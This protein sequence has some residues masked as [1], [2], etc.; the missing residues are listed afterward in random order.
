M[1]TGH[2]NEIFYEQGTYLLMR[3]VAVICVLLH[4]LLSIKVTLILFLDILVL[5]LLF[6][7]LCLQ[8]TLYT[9]FFIFVSIAVDEFVFPIVYFMNYNN[10]FFL[11]ALSHNPLLPSYASDID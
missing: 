2:Q 9:L 5:C 3:V 7:L 6:H 8:F 4:A 10:F 1:Y 11:S